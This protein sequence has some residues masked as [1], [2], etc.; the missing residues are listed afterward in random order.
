MTEPAA[1]EWAARAF[2]R[3]LVRYF[4]MHGKWWTIR[5]KSQEQFGFDFEDEAVDFV[6]IRIGKYR[7]T[8]KGFFSWLN[9]VL[10]SYWADL[11]RRQ[12]SKSKRETDLDFD[13]AE[14]IS[15]EDSDRHVELATPGEDWRHIRWMPFS[16]NDNKR[17][18]EWPA[19]DGVLMA[20]KTGFWNRIP[21]TTQNVWLTQLNISPA[22]AHAIVNAP[23]VDDRV[24]LLAAHLA[25]TPNALAKRWERLIPRIKL[26]DCIR[27]LRSRSQY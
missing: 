3:H 12:K 18:L 8:P 10:S 21:V 19:V 15:E 9:R 24:R 5:K 25:A 14:R 20:I 11:H 13:D 2:D 6:W 16:N 1:G 27:E 23:K 7:P 17:V 26:L 22:K 4:L